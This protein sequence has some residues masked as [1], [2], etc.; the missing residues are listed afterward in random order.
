CLRSVDV[1]LST[2]SSFIDPLLRT[3]TSFLLPLASLRRFML[4]VLGL[5]LQFAYFLR[6]H[7]GATLRLLHARS[8]YGR[9][10][11]TARCRKR[12]QRFAL[13]WRRFRRSLTTTTLVAVVVLR[14]QLSSPE[15]KHY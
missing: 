10:R 12:F 4:S 13:A 14:L 6:I 7:N 5:F 1:A 3:R 15:T 8:R 9:R 11:P 2:I